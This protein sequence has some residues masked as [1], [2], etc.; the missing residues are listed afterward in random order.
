M[1]DLRGLRWRAQLRGAPDQLQLL[2]GL[3]FSGRPGNSSNPGSD[4][5]S[6]NRRRTPRTTRYRTD[7]TDPRGRTERSEERRVGKEWV[8]KGRSRWSTYHKTKK[9]QIII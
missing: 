4:S 1:T 2:P 6:E 5:S 9:K 7:Q 8:S 3:Q